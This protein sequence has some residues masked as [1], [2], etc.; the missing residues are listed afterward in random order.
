MEDGEKSHA[1]LP[2]SQWYLR[3]ECLSSRQRCTSCTAQSDSHTINIGVTGVRARQLVHGNDELHSKIPNPIQK[4]AAPIIHPPASKDCMNNG[5][6]WRPLD[7][8]RIHVGQSQ[9]RRRFEALR[10][11]M[12]REEKRLGRFYPLYPIRHQ[13]L[14]C[15]K[16]REEQSGGSKRTANDHADADA[17]AE[18]DQHERWK[19][20]KL[21]PS[22]LVATP[23]S[24]FSGNEW[25]T[26]VAVKPR[27][28]ILL[29]DGRI[30]CGLC[31]HNF[32]PTKFHGH[33]KK[34]SEEI[35]AGDVNE[36]I[37]E[38]DVEI[39]PMEEIVRLYKEGHGCI[40]VF[41]PGDR[42]WCGL[43]NKGLLPSTVAVHL[44]GKRHQEIEAEWRKTPV[45]E[46]LYAEQFSETE[47][48]LVTD[49]LV[50]YVC[51]KV[52]AGESSRGVNEVDEKLYLGLLERFL[53]NEP[54]N[55]STFFWLPVRRLC[56]S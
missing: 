47:K 13:E 10:A 42:I 18:P 9:I 17:D 51:W 8:I 19:R 3:K 16:F 48:C 54:S 5:K 2:F 31:G 53:E 20:S 45:V 52:Q 4:N 14:S 25:T 49:D 33:F 38:M 11:A 22:G 28:V 24:L 44:Q 46:Q 12:D 35:V 32:S 27:L 41:T 26:C 37:A 7:R 50:E 39:P 30:A 1:V 40:G 6:S 21:P 23:G 15:D 56:K 29:P 34:C 55:A 43:C 36:K